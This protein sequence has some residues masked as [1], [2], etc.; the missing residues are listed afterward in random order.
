MASW[1][2]AWCLNNAVVSAVIPGCRD[3]VQLRRNAL[4]MELEL[5]SDHGHDGNLRARLDRSSSLN[6]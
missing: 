1:A 2:L 5:T 6:R 4:T 3:A